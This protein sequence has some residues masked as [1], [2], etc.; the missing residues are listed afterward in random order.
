MTSTDADPD[1][2]KSQSER[3]QTPFKAIRE[4]VFLLA[5]AI[6]LAL[7]VKTFFVQSFYIPCLLY[8]SPSPRD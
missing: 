1:A 2:D 4:T 6:I 7:V 3:K 5:F 8:T